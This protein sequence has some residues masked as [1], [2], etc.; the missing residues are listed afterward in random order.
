[1]PESGDIED[2]P[3]SYYLNGLVDVLAIK[4]SNRTHVTCGNCDQESS[5][6]SYCFQC[7]M[8]HCEDCVT[9]HNRMRSNANHRVL[10]LREFQD[11]D[12]ED[13][14]KRPAFCPK[15]RHQKEELKY[16]CKNCKTAVCQACTS[17]EHSGHVLEHIEVEAKRQKKEVET[18][19]ITHKENLH[20]KRNKLGQLGQDLGK[21]IQQ[22][23]DLKTNAQ[24]FAEKL[25]GIIEKTKD[26]VSAVDDQIERS[27]ENLTTKMGKIQDE[28]NVIESSLKTADE[29]LTRGTNAEVI[30]LKKSLD[31]LSEH[32]VQTNPNAPDPE[33]QVPAFVENQKLL[34]TVINEAIGFLEKPHK[35]NQSQS[36]AEGTTEVRI[37]DNKDGK[38][39]QFKPVSTF[40]ERGTSE[41]T[42]K[43]PLG[44]A[45]T[46][47]DEIAVTDSCNHRVQI[48]ERS[49]NFLKSF[50]CHG[51]SQ[52]EF[53]FPS[54]ICFHNNGNIFVADSL[55]NRIQIFDE[56]VRF[57]HEF[58]NDG[59]L[60]YSQL[61]NPRGLSLDSKS[62]IIVAD[63]GNKLIKI[64]SPDGTFVR[65][66]GGPGTFSFPVHCVQCDEYLIVLDQ[67]EHCIKVLD[68]E[69]N[70]QY[71][72]GKQGQGDG[73]FKLP[74][75]LAVNKL[76]HLLICDSG[77]DRIQIF[78][79]NGKFLGKFGTDGSNLGEVRNP[80]SSAV[81]SNG[82]VVVCEYG[83]HRIQTFK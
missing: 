31:T 77:N 14:L 37:N 76:G 59:S 20:A 24:R 36:I 39:F 13:V 5:E 52:G 69:G 72:I 21:L 50:G 16:F 58:G 45:V 68:R 22:G 47:K 35:S 70:Y 3:A 66:I 48:F 33:D 28:I 63:S 38:T 18:L 27:W 71:Q 54:G 74:S 23:E 10:A 61:S 41:G 67:G 19:M 30:Q 17:L 83:N 26:I 82:R 32:L 55:N 1:V 8:F 79:L 49:G 15:Q 62:N 7:C 64:F 2:L 75:F 9:A 80:T 78:E 40:G 12:Y 56:G 6:A 46:D 51:T 53:K 4:Q 44:V 25:I 57:V 42:F 11:K 43:G 60:D 73:E 65:K 34:D 81:L 29:L